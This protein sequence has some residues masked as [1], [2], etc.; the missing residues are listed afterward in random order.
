MSDLD[1]PIAELK[2]KIEM[3]KGTEKNS[4]IK[5]YENELLNLQKEKELQEFRERHF[6]L[7]KEQEIKDEKERIQKRIDRENLY[8]ENKNV[9]PIIDYDLVEYI[10]DET[11]VTE[12]KHTLIHRIKFFEALVETL[13]SSIRVVNAQKKKNIKDINDMVCIQIELP[14]YSSKQWCIKTINDN[15]KQLNSEYIRPKRTAQKIISLLE[16]VLEK[17][18]KK[19]EELNDERREKK[20]VFGNTRVTCEH[21]FKEY[22]KKNKARHLKQCKEIKK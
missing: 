17:L 9:E 16:A 14:T 7:Q 12:D 18:K 4:E 21:C 13:S 5:R 15:I 11:Y 8:K 3:L 20:K 10:N 6:L 1:E 19:Y 2:E 22:T